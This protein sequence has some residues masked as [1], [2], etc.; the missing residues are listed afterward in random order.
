MLF[1]KSG[2]ALQEYFRTFDVHPDGKRF[3]MLSSGGVYATTLNLVFNW[4]PE[5]RSPKDAPQ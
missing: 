4:R 5:V 3:L 2:F 1:S